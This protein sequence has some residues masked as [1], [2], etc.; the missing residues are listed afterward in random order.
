VSC[1]NDQVPGHAIISYLYR[2][3]GGRPEFESR[4]RQE[5]CLSSTAS[6]PV[7]GP[8]QPP[9]QAVLGALSQGVKRPWCEAD[10]SLPSSAEVKNGGAIRPFL[11]VF[12][13]WCLIKHRDNFA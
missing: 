9:A 6:R 4:Q 8:K 12:V 7:L 11:V 2:L 10:Q 1:T 13:T 3:Q 5:I